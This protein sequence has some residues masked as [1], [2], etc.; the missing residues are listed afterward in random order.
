MLYI[1][2][3]IYFSSLEIVSRNRQF[4]ARSDLTKSLLSDSLCEQTCLNARN[5]KKTDLYTPSL[6]KCYKYSA[7]GYINPCLSISFDLLASFVS[8]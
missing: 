8:L 2:R 1:S 4:G 6:Q 3:D 5:R 7:Y